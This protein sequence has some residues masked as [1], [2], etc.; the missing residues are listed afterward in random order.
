MDSLLQDIR[1]AVRSLRRSPGFTAVAMLTLA[2]AVGANAAILSI[3]DAVLF[4]PLPYS[5]P[6]RLFVLQ[7]LN[8]TTGRRASLVPFEQL[9]AFDEQHRGISHA[10]LS[11][12]GPQI[13]MMIADDT[14]AIRSLTVS[15]NYFDVLGVTAARGRLF[16]PRDVENRRAAVLSY[17][18]W[19][20]RFGGDPSIVGRSVQLGNSSFDVVGVLPRNF[21][22]PAHPIFSNVPEV[23]TVLPPVRAG[24]KGGTF[25][26]IVRLESGVTQQQAQAQIDAI[27]QSITAASTKD[28]SKPVMDDVRATVFPGGHPVMW[29]LLAGALALLLVG[30]AN[31]ANMLIVRGHRRGQ[32][33]AVR[34]ALGAGN[35]RLIRPIIFEALIIG[36]S[37]GALAVLV[38]SSTFEMLARQVPRFIYRNLPIGV[39]MRVAIIA[40]GL[41]LLGALVFSVVPAWRSTRIDVRARI[42]RNDQSGARQRNRFGRPMVAA[43][44]A[45]TIVLVFG[46]ATAARAFLSLVR[47][48]LG[49][50]PENVVTVTVMPPAGTPD[51]QGFYVRAL[52]TIARRPDVVSVGAVGSLPF[53]GSA[54]DDGVMSPDG[55]GLKAGIVPVLP[56]YFETAGIRLI[57]GRLLNRTD[58]E[59]GGS[60]VVSESA[61]RVLFPG[62]DPLGATFEHRLGRKFTVVGIV[63]DVRQGVSLDSPPQT[64]VIPGTATTRLG[65]I[66]RVRARRDRILDE[67]RSEIAP[68]AP[69]MPLTAAWWSDSITGRAEFRN[70]RFQTIVLVTFGA[71]ALGLTAL[72]VFGVI[73]FL[74]TMRTREMSVRIAMGAAPASLVTFVLRQALAPVAVGVVLGLLATQWAKGIARAQLFKVDT[75][76]PAMLAA[77]V[78]TVILA[79][80]AAAYLPAR[81]AARIDPIQALRAE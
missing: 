39:D 24:Q 21:F 31:L 57:R 48:Q 54:P 52:E 4:R 32:E 64:Y 11:D 80:A 5:D 37:A 12:D 56:G 29:F 71:L 70:P 40:V 13:S 74:V 25:Y 6:D 41:S 17:A 2:T 34:V 77:A 38:T 50:I 19:I 30:C 35:A 15:A 42:H 46:A 61:A 53:D 10:A 23:V 60:A 59:M 28:M 66:V 73:S 67:I 1:T 62:A 58:V 3:A 8:P 47:M 16:E 44:V 76:D 75:D 78:A 79:A 72:G 14:V 68:L 45:L 26:P 20:R 18:A 9:I 81:R 69:R 43:Q 65:I 51:R 7:M 63:A 22:F 27:V 33:M 36:L 49:F 55:R